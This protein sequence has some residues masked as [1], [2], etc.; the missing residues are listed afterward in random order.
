[1]NNTSHSFHRPKAR[2]K[3]FYILSVLAL[4]VLL[5]ISFGVIYTL[6]VTSPDEPEALMRM[7]YL[8]MIAGF[9]ILAAQALL[10][11]KRIMAVMG[12]DAKSAKEMSER[13]EQLA[14]LDD[15]TKAYNRGKFESVTSRELAN[16]RRYEHKLSG[17]MFDVDNFKAINEDH[18]YATGDRLLANMAHFV[19]SK[20]RNNDYLFRWRGGKFI[21]LAPHTDIDKASMVAEKLRQ[22]VSHK[23]FGGKIRMSISLSV[24]QA[25]PD[26]TVA[27]LMQR[28]QSGLTEAKNAGKN[29]VAIKRESGPL[30]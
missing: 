21:I 12:M 17:I 22:M 24:I 3:V 10:I 27:S 28:L 14:V 29:R 16:V 1:M 5:C 7:A 8:I 30:G 19:N 15:L 13:L 20:L 26:D 25:L 2:Y 18:G 11:F 23:L 6:I 4:A 9:L